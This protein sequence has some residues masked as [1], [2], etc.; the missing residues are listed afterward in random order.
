MERDQ[1]YGLALAVTVLIIIGWLLSGC[2][3]VDGLCHDIEDA[4]R[5]GHQHIATDTERGQ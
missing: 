4:A 1:R 3:M 5:Y 2:G